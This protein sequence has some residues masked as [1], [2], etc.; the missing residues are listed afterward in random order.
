MNQRW[1][2]YKGYLTLTVI[3]TKKNETVEQYR[4]S[5][6]IQKV[7]TELELLAE[8]YNFGSLRGSLLRDYIIYL[9][10]YYQKV[11]L[12]LGNA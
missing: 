8:S 1:R 4:F 6:E 11:T 7:E 3:P 5:H 12:I 2:K 9:K 10:S